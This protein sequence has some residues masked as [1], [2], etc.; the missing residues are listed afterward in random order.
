MFPCELADIRAIFRQSV[1]PRFLRFNNPPRYAAWPQASVQ[2]TQG[3]IAASSGSDHGDAKLK[4][5]ER[6]VAIKS[7]GVGNESQAFLMLTQLE[8]KC[9]KVEWWIDECGVG[10]RVL[11]IGRRRT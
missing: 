10:D 11:R 9:S 8:Q 1:D 3:K 7:I 2:C 5:N 6:T 4:R